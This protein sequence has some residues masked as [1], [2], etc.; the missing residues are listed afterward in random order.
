MRDNFTL[1]RN[2]LI[3]L[4]Q[5]S[6]A[7]FALE[8]LEAWNDE[9]TEMSSIGLNNGETLYAVREILKSAEI[10]K[11]RLRA[12]SKEVPKPAGKTQ[13]LLRAL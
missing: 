12:V 1:I 3:K 8:T 11:L 13:I 5:K 4:E 6:G 7:R 10:A 2:Y 9:L